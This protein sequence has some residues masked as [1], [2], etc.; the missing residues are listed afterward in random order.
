MSYR[1]ACYRWF[2]AARSTIAPSLRYHGDIYDDCLFEHCNGGGSWLDLGCGTCILPPWKREKEPDLIAG[3]GAVVGLDYCMDSLKRNGSLN[4]L[5]R[6]D[7]S[8]L[9]FADESFKVVTANMV[10]EHLQEPEPQLAEIWRILKPGGLLIFATP[11]AH[12]YTTATGRYLPDTIK[13][14]LIKA[15]E[16]RNEEDVFPAYYRLNT[17]GDIRRAAYS[18]GYEVESLR[19]LATVAKFIMVPPIAVI[20]LLFIKLLMLKIFRV[21]RPYITAV[22]RKP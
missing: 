13:K 11:N 12:G 4:A 21:L 1:E 16:G 3:A 10:F 20:E 19:L 22:L 15:L 14:A 18:S 2:N 6:G 5:V 9:P 8:H 17:E 7:I